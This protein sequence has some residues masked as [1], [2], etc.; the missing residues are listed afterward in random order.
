MPSS[1]SVAA[2]LPAA[3]VITMGNVGGAMTSGKPAACAAAT[4]LNT[5]LGSPIASAKSLIFTR[6]ISYGS[7]AGKVRPRKSRLMGMAARPLAG[8]AVRLVLAAVRAVLAQLNPVRV[9][10]PVRAGAVVAVLALLASQRD[11]GPDVSR[12]HQC[13]FP[14]RMKRGRG[15]GR[16][17]P[18]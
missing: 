10:T 16:T 12:S 5:G 13:L 3:A 4:S 9:V 6:L 14:R 8:L 17:S 1:G 11:L 18:R 15:E 7:D 2:R